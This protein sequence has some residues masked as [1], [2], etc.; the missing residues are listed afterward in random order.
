MRAV[1]SSADLLHAQ[2][3]ALLGPGVAGLA[4]SPPDDADLAA[5]MALAERVQV[6]L[7]PMSPSPAFVDM[8]RRKLARSAVPAVEVLPPQRR[9][10]IIGATAL[11]SALS[12]L[13]LLQFMRGSR[14]ALK[15]VS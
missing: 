6:A 2:A 12:L 13:G 1:V 8:L 14:R 10:W 3:D 15:K 9:A 11:G 7:A 4:T 5:L